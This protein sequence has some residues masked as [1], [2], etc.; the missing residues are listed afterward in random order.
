MSNNIT[1]TDYDDNASRYDQYRRPNPYILETMRALFIEALKPVSRP[2]L[3]IGCG[4][5]RAEQAL[6]RQLDIIGLDR[7]SGMLQQARNRILFLAQGDMAF[8]PFENR[9][10]AGVYFMQSLHHIGANLEI[11]DQQREQARIHVLKEAMRTLDRGPVVIVQRDPSQNAAVWF[12]KYFPQA[13]ETKLKIQP[14]VD[15]ILD[16]LRDLMLTDIQ[17]VPIDD[18]MARGFYEPASPLDPAFRRSFSDF[19]YLSEDEIK[20]GIER[21][22]NAVQDGSVHIE[23]QACKERF[24]E[25][26]GTVFMISAQKS[27]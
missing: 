26:G 2:I 4:T 22:Q 10:F 5:G 23:I 19:T 14:R 9:T 16:W 7:S 27:A 15:T 11:T 8:L 24:K 12:W 13:L 6:S 18:P 1:L 17:A 20:E 25:L 21:L 3:S